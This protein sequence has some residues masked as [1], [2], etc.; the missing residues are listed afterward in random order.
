ML[1]TPGVSTELQACCREKVGLERKLMKYECFFVDLSTGRGGYG[2]SKTRFYGKIQAECEK[3]A[4][5]VPKVLRT[6]F[7]EHWI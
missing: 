7:L 3:N 6:L 1:Q 2:R 5:F 4:C